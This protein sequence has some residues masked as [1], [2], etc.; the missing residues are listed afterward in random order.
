MFKFENNA[1]EKVGAK[2]VDRA[3]YV[4]KTNTA[5]K[6]ISKL[7]ASS[8][9]GNLSLTGAWVAILAARGFSLVEIGASE[10]V[11][12]IVSL[13]FEIPSGV[14]A[15]VFGRR[16]MLIVSTVMRMIANVVMILSGG[17]VTVCISIGFQA[18]AYNFSSGT[19]DA[20]AYDSLK[21]AGMESGFDKYNANQLIIY[22]LCSGIST[23]CAGFALFIGHRA[24]Y[25]TDLI[26]GVIQIFL[27]MSLYEV[28]PG[29]DGSVKNKRKIAVSATDTVNELKMC[30]TKSFAFIKNARNAMGL[31]LCNSLVGAVDI[32]LLFYLQAKLTEKGLPEE[33]LGFAL[34]FME[35]G[36]IVGSKLSVKIPKIS[37]KKMFVIS[38]LLVGFGIMA[39]HSPLWFVMALGGFISAMADDA[40][41]VRTNAILQDMFPSEQ[42]ATLTSVESFSFSIIMLFL[43]LPAGAFFTIW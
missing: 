1:P 17:L 33:A 22:R 29:N 34:L 26:T 5:K 20:L 6:Q 40:L 11:F 21:L 30:F 14:L 19:G 24:A 7:Y 8:V 27:L 37:Y 2:N 31:M 23:L 41:Q 28:Y 15:D 42:R 9:L 36:G 10:T 3:K 4:C 39:E 12:H 18:L 32:L 38:L 16:K 13:I 25:G 35:M 43:T